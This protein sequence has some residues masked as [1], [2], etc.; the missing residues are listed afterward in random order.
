LAEYFP[1][2]G[3]DG[4]NPVTDGL[5]VV[6]HAIAGARR[7]GRETDNG[8]GFGEPEKIEDQIARGART[9]GEIDLHAALD[10]KEQET[11]ARG[12]AFIAECTEHSGGARTRISWQG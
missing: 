12:K 6:G 7:V 1:G 9:V 10:A 4:N 5:K 11:G 8:D 3:I 2:I